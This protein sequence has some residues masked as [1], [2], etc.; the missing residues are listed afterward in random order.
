[1]I[2][3][4]IGTRCRGCSIPAP[5]EITRRDYRSEDLRRLAA[6]SRDGAQSRRLLALVVEGAR[7]GDAARACG[8]DRQT[9]RDWVQRFNAEGRRVG[10]RQPSP[11]SCRRGSRWARI[12]RWTASCAGAVRIWWRR[13]RP[14]SAL[15]TPSAASAFC[16]GARVFA[17]CR[18]GP[19][20][21]R[22]PPRPRLFLTKLRRTCS[23]P[24]WQ[25]RR[26]PADRAV[27]SG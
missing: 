12:L 27:V 15:P 24:A 8:M 5:V 22:P 11:N 10:S 17:I 9:L 4:V 21:L 3:E 16:S 23:R 14:R 6:A 20:L 26:R 25:A 19:R 18:P 13:S 7:R 2:Q 1:M